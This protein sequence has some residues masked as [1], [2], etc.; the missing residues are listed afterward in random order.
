MYYCG[1]FNSCLC[2]TLICKNGMMIL[3]SCVK[4]FVLGVVLCCVELFAL[5][6][7]LIWAHI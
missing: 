6:Y 7:M 3:T 5:C 2:A 4:Y 1:Q